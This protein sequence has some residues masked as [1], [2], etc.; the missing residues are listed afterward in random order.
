[1]P[2]Y[3]IYWFDRDDHVIGA[4]YLIAETDDDVRETAAARL[5]MTL[6]IEVWHRARRVV[7]VDGPAGRAA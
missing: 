1:M 2:A 4:D 6:A 5:G 7:R 3:R